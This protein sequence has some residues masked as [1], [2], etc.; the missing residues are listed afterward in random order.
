MFGVFLQVDVTELASSINGI[1]VLTVSFLIFM[2]QPGFVLLESGQVR[3]KNVANV[4]MKNQSITSRT[5]RSPPVD[6]ESVSA[7]AG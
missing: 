5:S 7:V 2:M 6:A 4:A 3:S 1:W